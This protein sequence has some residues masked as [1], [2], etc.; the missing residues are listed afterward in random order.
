MGAGGVGGERQRSVIDANNVTVTGNRQMSRVCKS[1]ACTTQFQP[2]V[3]A[4]RY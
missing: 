1:T 4:A 3:T 2:I